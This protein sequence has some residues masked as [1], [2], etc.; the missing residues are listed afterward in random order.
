MQLLVNRSSWLAVLVDLLVELTKLEVAAVEL[1]GKDTEIAKLQAN[2]AAERE[3]SSVEAHR[4]SKINRDLQQRLSSGR[5]RRPL[6]RRWSALGTSTTR[7][8]FQQCVISA[9]GG[10]T[11][12]HCSRLR[13]DEHCSK[14]WIK[15]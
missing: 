5:R 7:Q 10:D 12:E 2:F 11:S 8:Q 4:F 3:Q 9:G 15:I 13:I 6:I 1:A 14:P